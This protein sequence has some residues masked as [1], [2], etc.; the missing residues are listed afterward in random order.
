M[1]QNHQ[2][3]QRL[4]KPRY[5]TPSSTVPQPQ[6]QQKTLASMTSTLASTMFQGFGFGVGSSVARKAV[7]HVFDSTTTAT[8]N[9]PSPPPPQQ[10]KKVKCEEVWEN[11]KTCLNSS[12]AECHHFFDDFSRCIHYDDKK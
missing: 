2:S 7:D 8:S 3:K 9:G 5:A 1:R 11:Y 10:D 12:S 6:Q 4:P